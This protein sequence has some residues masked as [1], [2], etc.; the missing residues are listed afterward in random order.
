MK[1]LLIIVGLVV[2]LF[3]IGGGLSPLFWS[4]FT[5]PTKEQALQFSLAVVEKMFRNDCD[6]VYAIM[7]DPIYVLDGDA[8]VTKNTDTHEKICR[9]ISH[10]IRSDATFEDYQ[11]A[12]DPRILTPDEV[13]TEFPRVKEHRGRFTLEPNDFFFMGYKSKTNADFIWDDLFTF[14]VRKID[15]TWKIVAVS[16]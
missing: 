9:S 4:R 13:Y 11:N 15:Y 12:Y 3:I 14:V 8:V 1:K 10:A 2:F 5:K 16:G 7:N 6:G